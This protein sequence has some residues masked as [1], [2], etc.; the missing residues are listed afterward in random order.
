[1][2]KTVTA[3]LLASVLVSAVQASTYGIYVTP[4]TK[5]YSMDV[6]DQKTISGPFGGFVYIAMCDTWSEVYA[7]PT[8]APAKWIEL[9]LGVGFEVADDPGRLGGYVW[10]GHGNL[11]FTY[12]FEDGGSGP[13]HKAR[14]D[15]R[16]TDRL[17]VGLL[18]KRETGKGF[19]VGYALD[20]KT[21]LGLEAYENKPIRLS[22]SVSF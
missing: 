16:L 22:L 1:M 18:E 11:S 5:G 21:K 9:G 20:K 13:W 19:S 4:E 10:L 12:L 14:V 8:F 6:F 15:Y 7:G 2:L 17:T 3:F